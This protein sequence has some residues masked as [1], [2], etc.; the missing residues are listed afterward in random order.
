MLT[1][2]MLERCLV[3]VNT[4]VLARVLDPAD[5]GIVAMAASFVAM[6]D[7]FTAFGLDVALIQRRD[8]TADHYNTAWTL[9]VAS[10]VLV[11]TLLTLLAWPLSLFYRE[12]RLVPVICVFALSSLV[13][14]FE[15]IG[16]VEFRKQMNFRREFMFLFS[17]RL[18]TVAVTVPLAFALRSYWAM[19]LATLV[20]RLCGVALSFILHPFRPRMSFGA[21]GEFFHFSKWVFLQNMLTF[22]KERSADFVIGRM[23]G[24]HSLGVFNVSTDVANMPGTELVAPINRALLPGYALLAHDKVALR[25]EYLS[26]MA[27]VALVAV[28]AVTGIAALSHLVVA[29]LLGAKWDEATSILSLLAFV[30]IYQV[31]SSNAYSALLAIG[32]PRVFVK[33]TIA[34]VV[35]QLPLLIILTYF[36]GLQGAVWAYLIAASVTL[37]LSF[38]SICRAL[39]LRL[40]QLA[41]QFWRPVLAAALMF[42]TL[43]TFVPAIDVA[44]TSSAKAAALLAVYI[45]LGALTYCGGLAVLWFASRKPAG[46]EAMILRQI[47]TRWRRLAAPASGTQ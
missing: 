39:D 26:V 16:V 9:N 6:L 4:L 8:A 15:N 20:G 23:A 21:L 11:A 28:P 41:A 44:T 17:K 40:R 42:A 10:G 2:K 31:L 43:K 36:M 22:F 7:I 5:F 27:I 33:I 12:P 14:G 32:K 38:T 37:P 13:Q 29:A 3:L 34:Y 18:A 1:H 19:V 24:A 47:Q 46:A 35:V 45:P 30:S 25:T